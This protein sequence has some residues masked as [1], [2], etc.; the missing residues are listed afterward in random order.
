MRQSAE[1]V[2]SFYNTQEDW[3]VYTRRVDRS[4]RQLTCREEPHLAWTADE[5]KTQCDIFK[6]STQHNNHPHIASS[7]I[8]KQECTLN[9]E[10]GIGRGR[11]VAT[12]PSLVC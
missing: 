12:S 10:F 6:M 5:V 9:G 1:A 11:V 4:L 7:H 3:E 2:L 8:V